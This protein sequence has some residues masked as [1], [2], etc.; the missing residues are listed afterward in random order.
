ML[1]KQKYQNSLILLKMNATGA[2]RGALNWKEERE[3]SHHWEYYS[4]FTLFNSRGHSFTTDPP[5]LWEWRALLAAKGV[6]QLLPRKPGGHAATSLGPAHI[7]SAQTHKKKKQQPTIQLK[8][9][10]RFLMA[11]S[12]SSLGEG[13]M[14]TLWCLDQTSLTNP[15]PRAKMTMIY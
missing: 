9:R 10:C 6:R 2:N 15:P 11:S 5:S 1:F 14:T 4:S 7:Q 12:S 3:N 13:A 8:R